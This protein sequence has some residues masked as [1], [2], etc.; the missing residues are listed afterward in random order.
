M[1]RFILA[2]VLMAVLLKVTQ[3][4]AYIGFGIYLFLAVA[5]MIYTINTVNTLDC[6]ET[7]KIER[8]MLRS[9]SSRRKFYYMLNST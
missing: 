1:L 7:T 8:E 6:D 3:E 2:V 5:F 4:N 9:P